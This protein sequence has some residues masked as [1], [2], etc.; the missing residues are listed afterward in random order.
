LILCSNFFLSLL[1]NTRRTIYEQSDCGWLTQWKLSFIRFNWI[2][3]DGFKRVIFVL[4]QLDEHATKSLHQSVVSRTWRALHQSW[5]FVE[6]NINW[7]IRDG[8][9]RKFVKDSWILNFGCL[10]S[11][12]GMFSLKFAY[13][14]LTLSLMISKMISCTKL[15]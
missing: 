15:W 7:I 13:D 1:R 3:N 11:N 8:Q 14:V 2:Y 9:D 5:S 6:N 4:M 12:F 10:E